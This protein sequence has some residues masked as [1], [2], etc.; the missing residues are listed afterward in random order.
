MPKIV[1]TNDDGIQS[2]G[3]LALKKELETLGEILVIAPER[4]RSGIGKA[5]SSHQIKILKT[6]LSDGSEAYA[7]GGT[8]ADAYLLAKYK[9]LG[10]PPEL[11]VAGINIGP[12]LGVDDFFTSG[13]LGA[14]VEAAIHGTAAVTVSYCLEKYMEGQDKASLVTLNDLE[15]AAKIAREVAKYVLERGLPPDVDIISINVPEKVKSLRFEAT[16]LSYKG[17][18]DIYAPQTNGYLIESWNLSD[19]PDDAPGTDLCAVKRKRVSITPVKLKFIHNTVGLEPL[20]ET[21][22]RADLEMP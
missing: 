2:P 22:K 3:L 11:L 21:L 15:L 9:I 18:K 5:I 4:E 7:I 10:E 13:T 14:A 12:N 17:Y 16:C 20:L 19:Y 8:P 6:S 1:L